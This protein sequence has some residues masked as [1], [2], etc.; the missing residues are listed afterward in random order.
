MKEK[1]AVLTMAGVIVAVAVTMVLYASAA[2]GN[3]FDLSELLMVVIVVIILAAAI[4][5]VKDRLGN[6]RKGLPA[7]DERQ[8][9]VSYKAGYYAWIA[10]IWS[11]IGMMWTGI[12]LEE[13]F[14]MPELTANYVVAGVVLISSLVFFGMYF[15]LG[16]KGDFR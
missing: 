4:W 11:S 8:V 12:F 13:E 1:M 7:K 5:V 16:R 10:S 6:L 9:G 2:A 15:Y 3:S 14:G